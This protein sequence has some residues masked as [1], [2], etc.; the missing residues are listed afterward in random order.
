M[1]TTKSSFIFQNIES[2]LSGGTTVT[3]IPYVERLRSKRH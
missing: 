2:A 3:A 1:A